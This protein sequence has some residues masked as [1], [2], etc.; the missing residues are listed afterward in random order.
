MLI[1]T[2]IVEELISAKFVEAQSP[3][4]CMAWK[5]GDRHASILL[6]CRSRYHGSKVRRLSPIHCVAERVI[7][8]TNQRHSCEIMETVAAAK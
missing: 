3:H 2:H 1:K 7:T 5:C 8:N 4:L 6:R